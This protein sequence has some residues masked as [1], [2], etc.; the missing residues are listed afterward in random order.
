MKNEEITLS[1]DAFPPQKIAGQAEN[2]GVS[3]VNLDFW[4]LFVLASL[5]VRLLP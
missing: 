4:T 5:Q 2:I 3:K 1:I